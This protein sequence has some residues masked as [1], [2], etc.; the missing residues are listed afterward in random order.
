LGSPRRA[1]A[2]LVL[3][4]GAAWMAAGLAGGATGVVVV[5]RLLRNLLHGVPPFDPIAL[6]V[7]VATLLA[8]GTIAL[9][10]PVCRATRVDPITAIR[11]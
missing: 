10:V 8:C 2:G 1:I 7:S 4:A 11:V 5:A 9:L 6:G 3:W